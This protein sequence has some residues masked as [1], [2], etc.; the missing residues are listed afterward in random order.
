MKIIKQLSAIALAVTLS[1][2]GNI[3]ST[4]AN[5]AILAPA[6]FCAGTAGVSC[7]LIGVAVIGGISYYVWQHSSGN[8]IFSSDAGSVLKIEEPEDFETEVIVN[9]YGSS[10]TKAQAIERCKREVALHKLEYVDV[11][12]KSNGNFEC[13]GK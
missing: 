4:S 12:R 7:V 1:I 2:S 11:R 6:A 10:L 8:R 9:T 5:P 3:R 13:I